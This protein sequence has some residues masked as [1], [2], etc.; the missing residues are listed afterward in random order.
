MSWIITEKDQYDR[1][2]I[3][4]LGNKFLVGNGYL[5]YR[6]TLE[7][8]TRDQKTATIVSGLYDQV[9]DQWREPANL[10]NGAYVQVFVDGKPLKVLSSKV[11]AHSQ[12]LDFAH[13]VHLRRT[14]FQTDDGKLLLVL[15]RRFASL[16]NP[17]LMCLEYTVQALHDC[18]VVIRTG[19][20]GD[21]WDLN[22]PHLEGMTASTCEG[23]ISLSART[24]ENG[25]PIAVSESTLLPGAQETI[26]DV[27]NWIL[28]EYRV[29]LDKH[30]PCT[31]SKF[32]AVYTGTDSLDP[33]EESRKLCR[34]AA[35]DGF[36]QSYREHCAL[37]DERWQNCDIQIQGDEEAQQALRFSMYHLLAIAPVHADTVSIPARGLSGQVYKGAIFWDTEIFMLPFFNH[38]FPA[39][40]R[41]LL[42]YRYHTL[43]GA[44]RKAIEYGYRGAFY[45]WESQDT[46]DDACT[47]FNITDV[48][49]NRP[50][51]TYFRDKQVHISAD[52]VYAAWQYYTLTGDSS[53]FLDGMAEVIYECA[54]FFLSYLYY[55]PDKKRYEILDVTGPD[56]YHE[57]VHNNAFTNLLAAHTFDVCLKVN[58]YLQEHHPKQAAALFEKL[59]FTADIQAIRESAGALFIPQPDARTSVI[60]QFDGY[61][62][63]EDVSLPDLLKRKLH[64]HEYLGGGSGL[65]TTTQVIKQ[66]DV[67]L[68]L[69]LFSEEYTTEV[70]TSNWEFYEP[71]TEHGSSLSACSY[72]LVAAQIGKVEWAYRYFMK[73]AT[74][75]FTGE[76]KQYVGTLYIGGTHPAANGGAWMAAV[77]GLCGIRCAQD[78]IA[79]EPRLPAHWKEISLPLT[80]NGQKLTIQ[81]THESLTVLS[82]Q[83]LPH[84]IRIKTG[85]REYELPES[86]SISI[87]LE[88]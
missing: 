23:V 59:D 55:S 81:I 61:F 32:I 88:K 40:A 39:I 50:M 41:N 74:I 63:L 10:P 34:M 69:F 9:G 15:A 64:P 31:F 30:Q 42:M 79:L 21:V 75:D 46:G 73:T 36:A 83:P 18:D 71:R 4:R 26:L 52:I 56:E 76:S 47:L 87:R 84:V 6:G 24:H 2:A 11:Q 3:D 12:T 62:N 29:V 82:V 60:P 65:A 45:A 38:A 70:K 14:V 20:D 1:T 35:Q 68:A 85:A 5:G 25:V 49:T 80:F 28:R 54:R 72:S 58:E 16:V 8:Y 48:F 44:R 86:G 22:G 33:L 77:L 53:I 7:E 67:V 78:A 66:G 19:I 27:E 37:W 43:D 13:G 57:R 51:R 17:H